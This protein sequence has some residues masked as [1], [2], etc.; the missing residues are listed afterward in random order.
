M[1]QC[2]MHLSGRKRNVQTFADVGLLPYLG[3]GGGGGE[4]GL[5]YG[6]KRPFKTQTSHEDDQ[7]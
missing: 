7:T 5:R 1:T 2:E 3:I 4:C 6:E